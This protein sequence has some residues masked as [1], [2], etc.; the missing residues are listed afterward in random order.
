MK[1]YF[2]GA[3]PGAWDLIT[4]RGARL[5]GESQVIMYAGSLVPEGLLRHCR[6]DATIVNTAQ[7]SLDDQ[8]KHFVEART[9]NWDVARL[10]SGDP[11]IY[12]ATSEQMR[13]LEELG[14]E[15]EIVPGVSS[16]TAGA[17]VIGAELTKPGVSQTIILTRL[18]GRASAVPDTENLSLLASHKATLC[19][20]LSGPHLKRII[21]EV[22]PHYSANTPI[23]LIHRVTQEEERCHV[24]TLGKVLDEVNPAEW[25]LT[26]LVLIGDVLADETGGE[27]CLYSG[28]YTHKF[29]RATADV[30]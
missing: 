4:I 15:Y 14:I 11:A 9:N 2:I 23:A 3:G 30:S 28:N 1:V 20:F 12:G 16:F 13:R 29:R 22:S 19:V 27:S 10:H 18:S 8:A 24:S 25:A 6:K 7:L 17:A 26:T 5:L 21:D